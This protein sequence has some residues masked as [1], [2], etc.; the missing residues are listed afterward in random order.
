MA[1]GAEGAALT[2]IVSPG[3]VTAPIEAVM[4]LDP[5]ATPITTPEELIVALAGV[6]LT[7]V[8][9]E[10]AAVD[11]SEKVLVQIMVRVPPTVTVPGLGVRATLTSVGEEPV[12]SKAPIAG[13]FGRVVP[14]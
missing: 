3:E 1:T 10:Q 8:G 6:A 2:V 11:E 14:A 7:Q 4:T 5:A 13:G 12:N 9:P